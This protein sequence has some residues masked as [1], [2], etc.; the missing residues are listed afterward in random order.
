GGVSPTGHFHPLPVV[1]LDAQGGLLPQ[2]GTQSLTRHAPLLGPARRPPRGRGRALLAG[3]L[4]GRC[5]HPLT[6]CT[7][8]HGQGVL[9]S[10]SGWLLGSRPARGCA[11]CRVTWTL[12][13]AG[14]AITP[15]TR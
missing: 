1:S 2:V 8:R 15:R 9:L 7:E 14:C 6:E 10:A 12:P 5:E 4:P 3:R 11:P 13:R